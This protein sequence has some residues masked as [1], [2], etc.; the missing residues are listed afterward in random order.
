MIYPRGR[1]SSALFVLGGILVLPGG[2]PIWADNVSPS[3]PRFTK[4][5]AMLIVG[6]LVIGAA[7]W[8]R[9]REARAIARGDMMPD[10]DVGDR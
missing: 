9:R 1:L 4:A 10:G 6:A 8:L 5:F 3:N 7:F 2:A